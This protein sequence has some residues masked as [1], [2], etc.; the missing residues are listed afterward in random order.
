MGAEKST[1]MNSRS[2]C[3]NLLAVN[4]GSHTRS[5]SMMPIQD[6]I[7]RST[8]AGELIGGSG[9]DV[10]DASVHGIIVG[11]EKKAR[12][13]NSCLSDVRYSDMPPATEI[14]HTNF[15][16]TRGVRKADD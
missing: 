15:L 8:S 10:E 13:E 7:D 12:R 11:E 5:R 9:E 1:G 4:T 3:T 14:I 6:K 16:L 2:R